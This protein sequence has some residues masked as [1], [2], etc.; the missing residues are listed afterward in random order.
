MAL[1]PGTRLGRYEILDVLGAGGMGQVYRARDTRLLRDVAIKVLP[2][3]VETDPDR[4]SRFRREAVAA[5]AMNHP[6]LLVVH[7]VGIEGDRPFLVTE[8]LRGSTLREVLRHGPL[9]PAKAIGHTIGILDGL[10]ATH[11]HGIVHRDLKPENVFITDH[12]TPK[13]LDFGLAKRL[14]QITGVDGTAITATAT[15]EGVLLGSVGYMAPE[16][17]TGGDVDYRSDLFSVAVL[18]YEMLT[19]NA[20]FKRGSP[21]EVL[22]AIAGADVVMPS[23]MHAPLQAILRRGLEKASDKRFQSAS[24][25]AFALR[26][27]ADLPRTPSPRRTATARK[28]ATDVTYRRVTFD[29]GTVWSA[30][31]VPG[32]DL[33]VYSANWRGETTRTYST[34]PELPVSVP[35]SLPEGHLVGVADNGNVAVVLGNRW[36]HGMEL[37]SGMLATGSLAGSVPRKVQDRVSSAD[38]MPNGSQLAMVYD[39]GRLRRLEFPQGNTIY[40]TAGWISSVRVSRD[41][42]R[43]GFAD[44]PYRTD[45]RGDFVVADQAG[46]LTRVWTD[47]Y[48]ASGVAWS[49]DDREI[50]VTADGGIVAVSLEGERRFVVRDARRVRLMDVA[51]DGRILLLDDL[52]RIGIRSRMAGDS[53]ERDLTWFDYSVVRDMSA[54]G[55]HLLFFEAGELAARDYLVGLWRIGDAAPVRIGPGNPTSISPDGEQAL[56]ISYSG[57]ST[58]RI[59]PTGVGQ[60]RELPTPSLHDIHWATWHPDGRRVVVSAHETDRGARLYVVDPAGEMRP[61][62]PEGTVYLWSGISPEGSKVAALDPDRKLTIYSLDDESAVVVPGALP[63]ERLLAWSSDAAALYVHTPGVPARVSRL[64]LSTG[65]RTLWKEL[66]P[67]DPTGIARISPVLITPDANSYAYTYGRFL[68]TLYVVS[69]AR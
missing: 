5:G 58:V 3:D 69:G 17:L 39:R 27:V 48:S 12:G 29:A 13:I 49:P 14:P 34:R 63:D 37:S 31:F 64:D 55:T 19:G 53:A 47:L 44:H 62:G 1:A 60:S 59:V 15:L 40:E 30:R 41:G 46:R 33:I 10:A 43:V 11:R 65:E 26:L 16:Q 2:P 23:T 52:R 68:S 67:P 38:W 50:W 42:R 21:I 6:N 8:L 22:G 24:D 57:R 20:P 18:L 25:F 56:V 66:I 51:P 35:L 7:D 54:D 9:T 45:D 61:V 4:L 36:L 28:P 32:S